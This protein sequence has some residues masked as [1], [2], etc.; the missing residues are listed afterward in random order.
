M[1]RKE[2]MNN[3]LTKSDT[4]LAIEACEKMK[5][6]SEMVETEGNVRH[7]AIKTALRYTLQACGLIECAECH[8]YAAEAMTGSGLC[9]ECFNTDWSR[10]GMPDGQER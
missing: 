7:H 1:F 5:F 10:E 2:Y 3:E 6:L 9:V 8:N 4:K